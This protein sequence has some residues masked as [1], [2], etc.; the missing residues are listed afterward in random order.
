MLSPPPR[1]L[2][3]WQRRRRRL[4]F[5]QRAC[6]VSANV[7]RERFGNVAERP[8]YA[9]VEHKRSVERK[10]SDARAGRRPSPPR[11]GRL[12]LDT[13]RPPTPAAAFPRVALP[14]VVLSRRLE[15]REAFSRP[16]VHGRRREDAVLGQSLDVTPQGLKFAGEDVQLVGVQQEKVHVRHRVHVVA[17]PPPHQSAVAKRVTVAQVLRDHEPRRLR[18]AAVLQL[19]HLGKHLLPSPVRDARDPLD[20][21]VRAA[22]VVALLPNESLDGTE[23]LL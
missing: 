7:L 1:L 5:S 2:A 21:S 19:A 6:T 20:R 9:A 3:E 8:A 13:A 17:V 15:H 16:L 14:R 22:F 4:A 11:D 12:P 23:E 10:R 18:S